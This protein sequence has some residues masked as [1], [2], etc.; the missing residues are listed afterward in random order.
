MCF[1]QSLCEDRGLRSASKEV[2]RLVHLK[3]ISCQT[4]VGTV[5]LRGHSISALREHRQ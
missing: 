1:V 3:G 2:L 5:G 4:I